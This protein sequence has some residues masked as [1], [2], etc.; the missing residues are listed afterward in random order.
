MLASC[1][2]VS[3][4]QREAAKNTLWNTLELVAAPWLVFCYQS[5]RPLYHFIYVHT[6]HSRLTMQAKHQTTDLIRRV[7]SEYN[8]RTLPIFSHLTRAQDTLGADW[9]TSQ[10][11]EF[12]SI[13]FAFNTLR[14]GMWV[15]L[16]MRP[17][18]A[19]ISRIH[20]NVA[21][22]HQQKHCTLVIG[23]KKHNWTF[24]GLRWRWMND[25]LILVLL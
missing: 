15:K 10:T 7:C 17:H 21:I 9:L 16:S 24:Y 6:G 23:T 19:F 11:G 4:G 5:P 3:A 25:S 1:D 22:T 18:D 8:H 20:W 12:H 14:A 2:N 13:L